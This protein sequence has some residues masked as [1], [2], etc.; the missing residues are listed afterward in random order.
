[1]PTPQDTLTSL[2]RECR[3]ISIIDSCSSLLGWDER[4]YMPRKGA[5]HRAEQLAFLAGL[6]HSR[7]VDP[8][9]GDLI[10][11]L[12]TSGASNG[13]DDDTS[14][15]V[16]EVGRIYDREVKIPQ[17]LVEEITRVTTLAQGKWTEARA[18]SDFAAFK[19]WLQKVIDL[20][21]QEAEAVGY[22]NDPYNAMLDSYEPGATVASIEKIFTPLRV[23]LVALLDKI[24]GSGRSPNI[25]I[26]TREY[27][28][29]RQEKFGKEA[30]TAIGFDFTEGRLDITTHPFCSGIGPGDVR[31]TTRYDAHHFP[32]AFFGILHE[33]GHGIYDQ[34]LDPKHFGT[35]M[36]EMISLGIHESQS[37][38]WE[39]LVGRSRPFW[40]HFFPKAQQTF[41]EALSNVSADEFYWAINDVRP[42]LIRVEADE[43]TYNLHILLRFEME[44]A[45]FS[46]GLS[47][48]DIPGAWNEKFKSYFGL[49]PPDDAQ[50]CLQDVH[51]SAGYIGYFP[52]YCLGNLYAAQFFAKAQKDISDLSSQFA[53]GEYSA[54]KTWLRQN[55]HRHGRRYRA[56]ELV[57]RITG[58]P[59]SS[60]PL[61]DYM[62]RKFG[63]LYGF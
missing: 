43:A 12:R 6:S 27:P 33:A 54:L 41:P 7:L 21:K 20:K 17:S 36:G 4:T 9:V 39:N 57:E 48:D 61:I 28:V 14:V 23:E 46:G 35:P 49:T 56:G 59:L 11:T 31:I 19:P 38:M 60:K 24:R 52:T 32:G 2:I 62:T 44:R 26:I 40:T 50:G 1:M 22:K 34:G 3:E 18:K 55:I 37:R 29:D 30:A 45:F 10:N 16:R 53:K 63:E 25:G 8:R 51:W 47:V 5:E 13:G 42:S 15:M 58:L